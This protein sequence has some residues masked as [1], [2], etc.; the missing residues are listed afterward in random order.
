MKNKSLK[1]LEYIIDGTTKKSELRELLGISPQ[2]LSK[3]I[4]EL[5][6]RKLVLVSFKRVSL[7]P[8]FV[9]IPTN[10]SKKYNLSKLLGKKKELILLN[11]LIPSTTQGIARKI[12]VSSQTV[13]KNLQE[14]H[15]MGVVKRVSKRWVIAD[16]D[17]RDYL[18]QLIANL[19]PGAR[20][21]V[22]P[23]TIVET[24]KEFKGWY[25]TAFSAFKDYGVP[26]STVYNY[27]SEEKPTI[28]DVLAHALA[29]S[30]TKKDYTLCALLF[31]KNI[32]RI[33]MNLL[34]KRAEL[35]GIAHILDRLKRYTT[36]KETN[37]LFLSWEELKS[38]AD[39]YNVNLKYPE[40]ASLLAEIDKQL[41]NVRRGKKYLT[42]YLIGGQNMVI[43]GWKNATK[44]I[45]ILVDNKKDFDDLETAL[46]T[47]GYN[48]IPA[49]GVYTKLKP[50][51]ILDKPN[52][53]RIDL[54]L[55]SVM[56]RI[57]L[58]D[59]IKKRS[60]EDVAGK[61][62]KVRLISPTDLFLFKSI[63]SRSGDVEDCSA[64]LR[65]AKI[66][67]K[68]LLDEL[69]SQE[70]DIPI[71]YSMLQT[72]EELEKHGHKIPIKRRLSTHVTKHMILW[73]LGRKP[74]TFKELCNLVDISPT[75]LNRII[76]KL[77]NE[78]KIKKQGN[79][80]KVKP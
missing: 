24:K 17:V 14:L 6:R 68:A 5:K 42:V 55:K 11:T 28:E 63:T 32:H 51:S 29:F 20:A 10:L 1:L 45:D 4:G 58:S 65:K 67:W 2:Y 34:E 69:L 75:H 16:K 61:I 47:I 31:L 64:I 30:N 53:P 13:Y 40:T 43:R 35:F 74:H 73:T 36:N 79:V 76:K 33:D 18:N 59:D 70:K 80:Y 38:L 50:R 8:G 9:P 25:R 71:C 15:E 12:N 72:I 77:I 78:G 48:Q 37:N 52:Y 56:G 21:I 22:G 23:P 26:V 44:D 7:N 60:E 54:F 39:L 27:Y 57:K 62:L 46:L 66:N 19:H 49:E 41:E 3:L